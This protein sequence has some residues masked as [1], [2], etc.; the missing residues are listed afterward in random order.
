MLSCMHMATRTLLY[1]MSLT[2]VTETDP[3]IALKDGCPVTCSETAELNKI[4]EVTNGN[5]NG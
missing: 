4:A 2:K 5:K 3:R 1:S